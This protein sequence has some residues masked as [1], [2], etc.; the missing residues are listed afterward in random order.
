[1]PAEP[2]WNVLRHNYQ[3]TKEPK[4]RHTAYAARLGLDLAAFPKDNA[5]WRGD[6]GQ[7][8]GALPSDGYSDNDIRYARAY[9][10]IQWRW[11]ELSIADFVSKVSVQWQAVGGLHAPLTD[12]VLATVLMDEYDDE[13][14]RGH[15]ELLGLLDAGKRFEP[16]V[17]ARHPQAGPI[18]HEGR[19]RHLAAYDWTRRNPNHDDIWV[20][21]YYPSVEA[22]G[23]GLP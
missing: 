6:V 21:V 11:A 13:A 18:I 17:V 15:Q 23:M 22:K 2:A 16:V 4:K 5:E 1:M 3:H 10:P 20:E 7:M 19:H 8:L 14:R 9:V 12:Q